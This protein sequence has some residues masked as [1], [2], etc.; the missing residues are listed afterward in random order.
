M[1]MTWWLNMHARRVANKLPSRQ[2]FDDSVRPVDKDII[3]KPLTSVRYLAKEFAQFQETVI[4]GEYVAINV[5]TENP[6]SFLIHD[7]KVAEGYKKY[8][9]LLWRIAK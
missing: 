7:P 5:F 2:V 4:V 8:F 3:T 1:G 6:Y 9:E